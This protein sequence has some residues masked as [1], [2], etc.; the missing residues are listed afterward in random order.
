MIN[1]C[2][3]YLRLTIDFKEILRIIRKKFEN[4]AQKFSFNL[5][6]FTKPFLKIGVF[7]NYVLKTR[8]NKL[9]R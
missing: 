8:A 2:A 7:E 5:R 4:I 6:S 3:N 9:Y 1:Y